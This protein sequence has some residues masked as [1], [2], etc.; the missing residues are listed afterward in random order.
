MPPAKH[1]ALC[2]FSMPSGDSCRS[3]ALSGHRFCYHHARRSPNSYRDRAIIRRLD[4]LGD[5]LSAMDTAQLLGALHRQL[6]TLPKTLSRFPEVAFTLTCT[7]NRLAEITAST[8]PDC[9]STA[10]PPASSLPINGS[11]GKNSTR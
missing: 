6:C 10:K 11:T 5:Q 1:A 8:K 2:T 7:L 4:H 3:V 9:S